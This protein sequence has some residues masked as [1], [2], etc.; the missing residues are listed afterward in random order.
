MKEHIT[1]TLDW[2]DAVTL[3]VVGDRVDPLAWSMHER[4]A[5][6]V[7]IAIGSRRSLRITTLTGSRIIDGASLSAA[8]VDGVL[9]CA[10]ALDAVE[11]PSRSDSPE[12]TVFRPASSQ[13]PW[14]WTVDPD[15]T[16][17]SAV[18]GA[19]GLALDDDPPAPMRV[20]LHDL[21][22]A[23]AYE[24]RETLVVGRAPEPQPG[25]PLQRQGLIVV[26]A[27]G[28]AVS[29]SHLSITPGIG[30]LVVRD[31]W[32]TN[33]TTLRSGSAAPFRIGR[34]EEIPVAAGSALDL[35][36]DVVLVVSTGDESAGAAHGA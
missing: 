33:G 14:A 5:G 1:H 36:D 17:F 18:A 19:A 10:S 30:H 31:L 20:T 28:G 9:S 13:E 16:V 2:V 32:T 21:H 8:S 23:T 12:E 25:I 7:R 26:S 4:A 29:S 35:G 22:G 11:V 15:E 6:M 24:V 3:D 34:G 27:P